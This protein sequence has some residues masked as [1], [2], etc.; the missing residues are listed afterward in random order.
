[1]SNSLT[2]KKYNEKSKT[3]HDVDWVD[4]TADGGPGFSVFMTDVL[5][6]LA[7]THD[8]ISKEKTRKVLHN[9][10]RAHT[11]NETNISHIVD[12]VRPVRTA[13][14]KAH[15]E[16]LDGISI[17]STNWNGTAISR[18]I[19]EAADETIQTARSKK[20]STKTQTKLKDILAALEKI[21]DKDLKK[22][23]KGKLKPIVK[24]ITAQ[25]KHIQKQIK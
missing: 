21:K 24:K 20:K 18:V 6:T 13:L 22:E 8:D 2:L 19:E 4:D 5:S 12:T 3:K 7:L 10:L 1:M 25:V 14:V 23:S 17:T 15:D 9:R 16:F 11:K